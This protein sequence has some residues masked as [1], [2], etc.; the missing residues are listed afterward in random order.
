MVYLA[1][2]PEGLREILNAS[3]AETIPVWCSADA[4]SE[5][6]FEQLER[7]NVTRFSYSFADVDK[8]TIQDA[9]ATIEEHHPGKRVWIESAVFVT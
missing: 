8:A 7:G 5:A 4:L 2:T 9:L 3:N 6:E 1:L